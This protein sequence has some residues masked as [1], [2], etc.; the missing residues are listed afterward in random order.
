M[1]P[2]PSTYKIGRSPQADI[3]LVDATI[4][5]LHAEL[6][7]GRD[8]TWYLTDRDSMGGTFLWNEGEWNSI[9]QSF[10]RLGDRL[11]FGEYECGLDTLLHQISHG[12]GNSN[13]SLAGESG[14]GSS[15]R[16]DRPQGPVRRDPVTGDLIPIEDE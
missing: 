4:S 7:R 14:T 3:V 1:P 12:G 10:V 16:D 2:S 9:R 13:E 8:G 11:K 5:R 15:I 6:V